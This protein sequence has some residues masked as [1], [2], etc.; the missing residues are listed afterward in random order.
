MKRLLFLFTTLSLI[1]G[2]KDIFTTSAFESFAKSAEDMSSEEINSYLEET[3]LADI[4][5]EELE[6]IEDALLDEYEVI[7][8]E[9]LDALI[10]DSVDNPE[11]Q[12]ALEEY[13]EE[14]VQLLEINM[15]QADVEGLVSDLITFTDDT[16]EGSDEESDPLEVLTDVLDDEE[17]MEDMEAVGDFAAEAFKADED[18]LTGEQLVVGSIGLVSDF[19][20]PDEGEDITP[21][22]EV[23]N[24]EPETL[25]EE[26]YSEDQ[27]EDIQLAVAMMEAADG[28]L[29]EEFAAALE[30]LP[31]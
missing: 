3:P 10:A 12:E 15:E 9:D 20:E 28:K 23:E 11:A 21:I 2:C 31:I 6:I 17:R 24:L 19:I 16:D 25:A 4:P 7:E 22:G 27:I 18:S 8:S 26:G 1:T 13:A 5:E 14:N 29:D 30:D